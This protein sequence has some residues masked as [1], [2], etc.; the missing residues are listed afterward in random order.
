MQI[1]SRVTLLIA[2]A[3]LVM[4]ASCD[5]TQAPANSPEPAASEAPKNPL[6]GVW[7][8]TERASAGESAEPAAQGS[9][10]IFTDGYYSIVEVP[11]KDP[12]QNSATSWEPT[13]AEKVA[14]H[15]TLIVNTGT[16]SLDGD[17]VTFKPMV[18]KIP[19]FVGG[20]AVSKFKVEGG[21]LTLESQSLK[22][23]GGKSPEGFTTGTTKLKRLE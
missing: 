19:E 2:V 11:G 3:F 9:V 21:E 1:I 17:T 16:Y 12:R 22:D 14:Q 18:A 6:V 4:F 15:E 13:D 8:V 5:Q 23:S 10:Y 20:E 7:S